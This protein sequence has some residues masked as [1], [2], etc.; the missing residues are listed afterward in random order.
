MFWGWLKGSKRN[1]LKEPQKPVREIPEGADFVVLFSCA[2]MIGYRFL[3]D[4]LKW[5][6]KRAVMG[7]CTDGMKFSMLGGE[8]IERR[9]ISRDMTIDDALGDIYH[10]SG[11]E[12]FNDDYSDSTT[13]VVYGIIGGSPF[14]IPCRNA[15]EI[16]NDSEV[17]VVDT[18][19]RVIRL[20]GGDLEVFC[21]QID[22]DQENGD[23]EVEPLDLKDLGATIIRSVD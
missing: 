12:D 3:S 19:L 13:Y 7:V 15:M 16:I 22:D 20:V 10:K 1:V 21:D 17:K 14:K 2:D 9:I 18:D 11:F 4:P 6:S 23:G 5:V 8:V